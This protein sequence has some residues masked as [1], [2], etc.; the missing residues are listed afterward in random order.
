M[1][2]P[3]HDVYQAPI[4]CGVKEPAAEE[5]IQKQAKHLPIRHL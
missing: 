4:M 2:Y 3:S 5:S 1:V